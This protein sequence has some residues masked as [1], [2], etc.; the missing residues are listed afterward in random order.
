[1]SAVTVFSGSDIVKINISNSHNDA[2]SF[3]RKYSKSLKISEFKVGVGRGWGCVHG[4]D[5]HYFSS[6]D[7]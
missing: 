3:E 5:F 2:V 7:N 4:I 6:A 1:M